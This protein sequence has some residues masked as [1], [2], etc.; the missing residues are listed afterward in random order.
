[1]RDLKPKLEQF[2]MNTRCSPKRIIDAH[3]PDQRPQFSIDLRS[4][5]PWARP[6]APV[7]AKAGPMPPHERLG[8]DDREDLQDR[9]KP[10]IEL[11]E[12]PAIIAREPD[13]TMQL[14][15]QDNQLMSERRIL[16]FKSAL[17]LERRGQDGQYETE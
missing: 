16:C 17:R 10:A 15:P 7:A 6:P 3:S 8:P 4:P 1:M 14:T 2:A 5:S 11:N 9:W 12:E 13:A